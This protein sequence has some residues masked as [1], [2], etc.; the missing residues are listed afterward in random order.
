MVGHA[1]SRVPELV[2][3]YGRL[4][5]LRPAIQKHA[6]RINRRDLAFIQIRDLFSDISG[7]R[8]RQKVIKTSSISQPKPFAA[9]TFFNRG[10]IQ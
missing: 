8:A 1:I 9:D 6:S 3:G 2:H 4:V 10:L 7:G 5:A